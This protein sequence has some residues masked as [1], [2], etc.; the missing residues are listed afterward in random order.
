[1]MHGSSASQATPLWDD[2]IGLINHT[3]YPTFHTQEY[4]WCEYYLQD[5]CRN[6]EFYAKVIEA[7]CFYYKLDEI[8][9]AYLHKLQKCYS[10]FSS[11]CKNKPCK[12]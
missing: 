12:R 3:I 9:E 11:M 5:I 10:P 7:D 6:K 2:L 8:N 4:D 1:M